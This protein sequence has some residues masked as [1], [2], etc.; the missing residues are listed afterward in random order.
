MT[1]LNQSAVVYRAHSEG[2]THPVMGDPMR[3]IMTASDTGGAY[4]I[5]ESQTKPGS[6]APPHIHHNEEE[7]MYVLDGAYEFTVDG[8][9]YQLKQGDYIHIPRGAVRSFTNTAD[10]ESRVLIM[11]SPGSAAGFYVEMGKL[12]FPPQIEAIAEIGHRYN[13][14]IVAG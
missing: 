14:E 1:T 9:A 7:C 12:P 5:A 11:H 8:K 13:I 10:S 2:E 6:G 4:A 3:F